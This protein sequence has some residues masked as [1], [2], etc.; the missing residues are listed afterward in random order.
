MSDDTTG[1]DEFDLL[2]DEAAEFEVA[3]SGRP[4]VARA[5]VDPPDGDGPLSAIVWG[6]LNS[7]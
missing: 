2:R 1:V 7:P 3:W 5:T 6:T 4:A